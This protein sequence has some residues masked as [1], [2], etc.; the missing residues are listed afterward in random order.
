MQ[1]WLGGGFKST[2]LLVLEMNVQHE[3]KHQP[4]FSSDTPSQPFK[5]WSQVARLIHGLGIQ[6]LWHLHN[7]L[8]CAILS[9]SIV[10]QAFALPRGKK[11][12]MQYQHELQHIMDSTC[13][14]HSAL[15]PVLDVL[16][17]H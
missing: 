11:L 16:T 2:G 4:D 6:R 14:R 12:T 17:C 15:Q 5:V 13:N 3:R 8:D 1:A 9:N 7:P 10:A